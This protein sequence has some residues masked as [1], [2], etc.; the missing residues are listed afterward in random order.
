MI[1]DLI[2]QNAGDAAVAFAQPVRWGNKKTKNSVFNRQR[3]D[4]QRN[5]YRRRS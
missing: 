2:N 5:S 1:S 4:D 3:D